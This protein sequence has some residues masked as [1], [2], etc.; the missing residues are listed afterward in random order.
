MP[1]TYTNKEAIA[2]RALLL[3][4]GNGIVSFDDETTESN[5][6]SQVY[7]DYIQF[8]LS[9]GS[10]RF[11]MKKQQLTQ[12]DE[13]PINEW[14]Y[15][16]TLPS[17]FL[18]LRSLFNSSQVGAR[19]IIDYELYQNRRVYTNETSLYA[20]YLSYPDESYWPH[21]FVEFVINAL[22]YQLAYPLTRDQNLQEYY[23]QQ[24]FGSAAENWQGGLY[25]IASQAD[26]ASNPSEPLNL[27]YLAN[28][29]HAFYGSN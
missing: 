20:D 4:G 6:V 9:T 23:K 17:D 7:S 21:Y 14:T 19:T 25:A 15:S 1:V 27:S 18:K 12:L 11:A 2:N 10:W 22:A 24:A 3:L 16:Y 28:A 8:L 13:D 5:L 26:S 29:R